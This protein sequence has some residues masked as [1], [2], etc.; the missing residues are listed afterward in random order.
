MLSTRPLPRHKPLDTAQPT[1]L[2]QDTLAD[3]GKANLLVHVVPAEAAVASASGAGVGL[4]LPTLT[5]DGAQ[6]DRPSK[7]GSRSGLLRMVRV[8][9]AT[10][11]S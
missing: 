8:S 10:A 6:L 3:A 1:N 4:L 2:A 9:S 5:A 7:R 11:A